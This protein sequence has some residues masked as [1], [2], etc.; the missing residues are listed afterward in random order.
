MLKY[1]A[2]LT[3]A[4]NPCKAGF[5]DDFKNLMESKQDIK[6][7]FPVDCKPG[8]DCF[9]QFYPDRLANTKFADY[10]CGLRSF[11]NNQ[12]TVIALQSMQAMNNGV[13]VFAAADGK[14]SKVKR[15]SELS[16]DENQYISSSAE[17][18]GNQV[19]INHGHGWETHYCFLKP[20]SIV[21]EE[22]QLV[23][24]GDPIAEVGKVGY[25]QSLPN[26]YFYVYHNKKT[27][28]PFVGSG[29]YYTCNVYEKPLWLNPIPYQT[30]N[31]I[32]AGVE[33]KPINRDYIVEFG[34]LHK[35]RINSGSKS[36]SFW[37]FISGL[38]DGDEE[39]FEIY[40]PGGALE[41]K[42][43][44]AI[45]NFKGFHYYIN[46]MEI[47]KPA[48]GFKKGSWKLRYYGI[49]NSKP[50]LKIERIIEVI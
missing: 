17:N 1:S 31:V 36:I 5:V 37:V 34:G 8:E 26:L 50:I 10:R 23:K 24:Q 28:D 25:D 11:D 45:K 22:K 40:E 12:A 35:S 48:N 39:V 49:R 13:S 30:V 38:Q 42:Y 44:G 4:I 9:I 14:V 19:V 29:A 20:D 41:Y 18:C 47:D 32:A 7:Q 2:L 46:A 27:V 6:L 43:E 15:D 21:V 3:L 16:D 33:D